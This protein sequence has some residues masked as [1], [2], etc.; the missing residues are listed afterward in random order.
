LLSAWNLLFSLVFKFKLRIAVR[1][2]PVGPA[3]AFSRDCRESFSPPQ[4]LMLDLLL[5][6][7]A[8][9]SLTIIRT[10]TAKAVR[11]RSRAFPRVQCSAVQCNAVQCN[12]VHCNAV[13]CSAVQSNA[14][15]CS[16]L[17]C[18]AMQCSAMHTRVLTRTHTDITS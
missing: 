2:E 13:Q 7:K 18:S 5:V 12:A 17:Q 10:L 4:P 11:R 3:A 6:S 15:Q 8:Y 14:V 16:A 9:V 1:V